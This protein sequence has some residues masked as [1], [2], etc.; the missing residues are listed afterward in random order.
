MEGSEQYNKINNI[1][2]CFFCADIYIMVVVQ[3]FSVRPVC[4]THRIHDSY[5]DTRRQGGG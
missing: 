2:M 1:C 5:A 4:H 3:G